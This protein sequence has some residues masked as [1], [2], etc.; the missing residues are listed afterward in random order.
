MPIPAIVSESTRRLNP[1]LFPLYDVGQSASDKAPESSKHQKL[2]RKT[3]TVTKPKKTKEQRKASSNAVSLQFYAFC[4]A[5]GIPAPVSEYRFHDS[6]KWRFDYAFVDH[7]LG[8]EID[9]GLFINGGHNRGAQRQKDYEKDAHALMAGWRVLRCSTGQVKDGT[10]F[11]WIA[12]ILKRAA[13]N[14]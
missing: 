1:G 2:I 12:E 9:G 11:K 5:N 13:N 10:V 14:Y 3:V 4:D 8:V 7:K 6:R